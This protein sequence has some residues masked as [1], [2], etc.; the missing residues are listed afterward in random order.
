LLLTTSSF[1]A[2]RRD[3]IRSQV[4]FATIT[5]LALIILA[6]V[7]DPAI[8]RYAFVEVT[9][10]DQ[11]IRYFYLWTG[12]WVSA[13]LVPLVAAWLLAQ[14]VVSDLPLS[15]FRNHSQYWALTLMLFLIGTSLAVV[16]QP[17][18]PL[19][20]ELGML[21]NILAAALGTLTITSSQ[22]PNLPVLLRR[23]LTRVSSSLF[24]FG[25]AA[26]AFYIVRQ[27]PVRANELLLLGLAA[28]VF[29]GVVIAFN[30]WGVIAG[31]PAAQLIPSREQA[32][33]NDVRGGQKDVLPAS[34]A[35]TFATL[36]SPQQLGEQLMEI[37][38]AGV[39]AEDAWLFF[40][41]PGVGG[42]LILRGLAAVVENRER[43]P[44]SDTP[45]LPR[46]AEFPTGSPFAAHLRAYPTPL[47]QND[48][49]SL[50]IFD[51]LTT[52]EKR[53]LLGWQRVLYVP[54]H[55]DTRLIGVL[56]LGKKRDGAAYERQDFVLLQSL[57]ALAGP[58]LVQASFTRTLERI[59]EYAFRQSQRIGR[60]NR[61]LEAQL[62]LHNHLL[63][64]ISPELRRPLLAIAESLGQRVKSEEW[65]V[66]GGI[67]GADVPV[68]DEVRIATQRLRNMIERLIALAALVRQQGPL[69]YAPVQLEDVVDEAIRGLATMAEA[70]QVRMVF[71]R[72]TMPPLILA[73]AAQLQTALYH[74]IHNAIKFNRIGGTVTLDVG[75]TDNDV[76]L[77]IVDT[78][79]GI[80]AEQMKHLWQGFAP[81]LPIEEHGN[82]QLG[83]PV[84]KQSSGGLTVT[85]LPTELTAALQNYQPLGR[86]LMIAQTIV[87]AHGGRLE[88]QS[89]YG[90]GST[91]TLYLPLDF[92]IEG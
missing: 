44:L 69:S 20:Q 34:L 78:G 79:V 73:D 83:Q 9:L 89:V 59:N 54:M 65:R 48:L 70:R 32:H 39:A 92:E 12:I 53:R 87:A 82:G 6:I 22:L 67:V 15:L 40:S 28:A 1:L 62:T 35:G 60:E 24:L 17:D 33:L 43:K 56:A 66:G 19:W 13:C 72:S 64:L 46:L 30:R 84:G 14:Q 7:M 41:E 18:Q 42:R 50:P 10:G 71:N 11:T 80:P 25:L 49:F 74:L 57:V 90:R 55:V 75:L 3:Q 37:A 2:A 81:L 88:A 91:F 4:Q 23:L 31:R 63:D 68:I 45:L 5:S 26:G 52:E 76:F 77:R 47:L 38:R 51:A 61:G 8:W 36:A 86:G 27:F 58:F 21:V 85:K 29:T 16:Q